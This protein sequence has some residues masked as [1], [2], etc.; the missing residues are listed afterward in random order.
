MKPDQL[1]RKVKDI[2]EKLDVIFYE[3]TG[4][5]GDITITEDDCI[6]WTVYQFKSQRYLYPGVIKFIGDYPNSDFEKLQDLINKWWS[7]VRVANNAQ[8][9]NSKKMKM[10]KVDW[11]DF[12]GKLNSSLISVDHVTPAD[13]NCEEVVDARVVLASISDYKVKK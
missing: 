2:N 6:K 11:L 13:D 7:E 8:F 4:N 3:D 10:V 9:D 5:P 1:R 12:D